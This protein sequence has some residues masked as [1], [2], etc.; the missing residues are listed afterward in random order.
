MKYTALKKDIEENGVRPIYLLE[1]TEV[2]FRDGGVKQIKNACLSQPSLNYA[3]FDGANLKGDK[4]T[5]L[6]DGV[7]ALPFLSKK[8]VVLV[9]EFYPSEKDYKTY[10][11]PLFEN[12]VDTSVIVIV[13]AGM[14]KAK[15]GIFDLKK[16]PN[17]TVVECK[18]ADDE[19]IVKWIYLTFK[20]AGIYADGNISNTIMRYCNGDMARISK[21]V[22]KL[23]EYAAA[24]EKK[25]ID[26]ADVD[27]LVYR[28]NEYKLYELTQAAARKDYGKF[29]EIMD[30]MVGKGFD[31]NAFLNSLCSHFRTLYEVSSMRGSDAQ[32]ASML[33]MK[34]YGVRKSR[35][36]ASRF[37]V[38]TLSGYYTDIYE[39]LSR[40]RSGEI[41]FSAAL[42]EIIAKIF[43]KTY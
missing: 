22:E 42:K 41:T 26:L 35:E 28:D 6:V 29:M 23:I 11:K 33:D 36:Q 19:S 16:A 17:V 21:E 27:A 39:V 40:A 5:A 13:N 43:F 4:L 10:L 15:A 8:R 3:A 12:P 25:Q 30:G 31:E 2:Y 34:E 7:Y 1:G 24:D 14:G 18:R 32:V 9:S 38:D 20:R 37:S